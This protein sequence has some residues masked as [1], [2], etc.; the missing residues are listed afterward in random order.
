MQKIHVT[1]GAFFSSTKGTQLNVYL[2]I[3]AFVYITNSAAAY[4]HIF[5]RA[6]SQ[7]II[8]ANGTARNEVAFL[9]VRVYFH[10]NPQPQF[11][12]A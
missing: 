9:D 4:L 3:A 8:L 1:V 6:M 12:I 7:Q 11:L 10:S 2:Y 5:G